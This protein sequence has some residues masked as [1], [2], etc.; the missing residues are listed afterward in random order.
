MHAHMSA[1]GSAT[2]VTICRP[3]RSSSLM[4][5]AQY[6]LCPGK[7]WQVSCLQVSEQR[8]YA[9]QSQNHNEL[10]MYPLALSLRPKRCAPSRYVVYT[11]GPLTCAAM[12][13]NPRPALC[14]V[15][16]PCMPHVNDTLDPAASLH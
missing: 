13:K 5:S 1:S 12:P 16:L 6:L 9:I 4:C 7:G 14:S 10:L 3:W 15:P 2:S 8:C 11:L